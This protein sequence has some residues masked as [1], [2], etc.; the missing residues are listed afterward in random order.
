MRHKEK[1]KPKTGAR[2][3]PGVLFSSNERGCGNKITYGKKTAITVA[4]RM[5][6]TYDDPDIWPYECEVCGS[7]HVGHSRDTGKRMRGEV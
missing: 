1:T 6:A 4:R 5:R 7:W 2:K 3:K